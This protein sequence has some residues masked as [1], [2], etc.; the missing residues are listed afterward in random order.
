MRHRQ[1]VAIRP[2]ARIGLAQRINIIQPKRKLQDPTKGLREVSNKLHIKIKDIA[3]W[4]EHNGYSN[5]REGKIPVPNAFAKSKNLY[6]DGT[7]IPRAIITLIQQ[8]SVRKVRDNPMSNNQ[9]GNFTDIADQFK[10]NKITRRQVGQYLDELGYRVKDARGIHVTN[11]AFADGLAVD[12]TTKV[13]KQE[14]HSTIVHRLPLSL[15]QHLILCCS[16]IGMS[17]LTF[18]LLFWKS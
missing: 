9:L 4:L 5:R 8:T 14:F 2:S 6:K 18:K 15:I 17:V 13:G 11:K 10:Q 1:R 3:T 7:W 16:V 12:Q